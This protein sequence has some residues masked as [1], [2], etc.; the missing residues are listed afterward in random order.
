MRLFRFPHS[1]FA[2]K[3]QTVLD[4]LHLDY[5]L[6]DVRYGE[7]NELAELTGGYV[8]VPVLV[9]GARVITESRDI[10]AHLVARP[11][12]AWLVPSPL[13]GPIWAYHDFSDGPL[14]DLLFRIASPDTRAHWPTPSDR[15]LY[16]MNKERKFGAGCIDQW[17]RD[18]DRLIAGAQRLL[19]PT[20]S[21]LRKQPFVFGDRPT[22]ADAALHGHSAMLRHAN[23]ELLARVSPVLAEHADRMDRHTKTR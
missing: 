19:A 10:C 8:Y 4:L 14:E 23:P 6:V 1:P 18:R 2:H 20:E 16:T 12:A 11:D 21:T 15:A 13:E 3:V 9:D 7:R 5:E 17:L 22:L